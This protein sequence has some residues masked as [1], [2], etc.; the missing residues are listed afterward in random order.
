MIAQSN[1]KIFLAQERGH[2]ECEWFRSYQT[3]CFGNYQNRH[4]GPF[5]PLYVCNDDT[6]AGGRK[7][8]LHVEEDSTLVFVPCVGAL[9]YSDSHGHTTFAEA[10]E[11]LKCA[12]PAG[13]VIEVQNPYESELINFLHFWIKGF[14][15]DAVPGPEVHAFDIQNNRNRLQELFAPDGRVKGFIGKFAGREEWLYPVSEKGRGV[16]AFVLEGAFEVQCRLLEAC[17]S[18][19]LQD[20]REV[21]MEALSNDAIVLLLEVGF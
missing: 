2:T 13:T 3:F 5:G 17:D 16:F 18:L 8:T 4:K 12:V 14:P 9:T 6:L 10:G 19:A 21:D 7:L 15:Q 11:T 20:V 1:A